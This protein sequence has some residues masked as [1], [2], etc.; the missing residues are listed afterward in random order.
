[1]TDND[2]TIWI[3][4]SLLVAVMSFATYLYV[5]V[6]SLTRTLRAIRYRM[7]THDTNGVPYRDRVL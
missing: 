2:F 3:L 1:M 6:K 4:T 7:P 5:R